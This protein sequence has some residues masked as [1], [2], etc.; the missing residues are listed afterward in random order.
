MSNHKINNND[1]ILIILIVVLVL[2]FLKYNVNCQTRET[3]LNSKKNNNNNNHN[4]EKFQSINKGKIEPINSL[5]DIDKNLFKVEDGSLIYNKL[6][7]N[8]ELKAPLEYISVNKG[9]DPDLGHII[10][11]SKLYRKFP[12]NIISLPIN[13]KDYQYKYIYV[14]VF[15]DGGLYTKNSLTDNNWEGP[16]RNSYYY[17]DKND[18]YIPMRNLSISNEGRLLG[19]GY[20]GNIYIKDE[21]DINL[22]NL[23]NKNF[24]DTYKNEWVKYHYYKDN[25]N[26]NLIYLMLL[27]DTDF[28][29]DNDILETKTDEDIYYLGIDNKG[30]LYMLLYKDLKNN[31]FKYQNE[32]SLKKVID[33][34]NKL[35]KISIDVEGHLLI[36]NQSRELMRSSQ[37]LKVVLK[38]NSLQFD[39]L[40]INNVRTYK[41]P[42]ILY[43]IIHS[44]D[45]RLYGVGS[46]NKKVLLLKQNNI[47]FLQSFSVIDSNTDK[48]QTIVI[49]EKYIV[50]YKS[51]YKIEELS[52]IKIKSLEESYDKEINEDN[53]QF[54]TFCRAQFPNNY[55]DI[56][57]LNKIDEF[58][59]KIEKLKTVKED[60][61]NLDNLP[62]IQ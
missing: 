37:P 47:N 33:D 60:L 39:S 2:C 9:V 53:T 23:Y 6:S 27:N 7:V 21:E 18:K 49:P 56:N 15:N 62:T 13:V 35:Y 11:S 20:D 43:D 16:H 36:I 59:D 24:G 40:K 50:K 17:N 51:N 38:N 52:E 8:T 31:K 3:F 32:L 5:L 12:I 28:N 42:N 45:G 19:V 10:Q 29:E 48:N 55:I 57:M 46:I 1:L 26:L 22:K 41:N 34:N 58:Q 30:K 44:Q 54:K 61:I 4:T 25:N 14:A